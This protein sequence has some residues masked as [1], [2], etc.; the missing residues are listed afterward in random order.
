M[1]PAA[2]SDLILDPAA[3]PTLPFERQTDGSGASYTA[4]GYIPA[5]VELA[6]PT[7]GPAF[8]GVETEDV[9]SFTEAGTL[10]VPRGYDVRAGDRCTYQGRK[11]LVMGSRNWDLDHPLTG[12]DF[13]WMTLAL[14]VDPR[15]LIGDL[16]MLRGQQIALRPLV[17]TE[18]P[19]GGKDYGPG[20]ARPTQTFVLFN[21]KGFDGRENSQ[22]DRGMSRK[23]Q[24]QLVGAADAQIAIGD[25]WEDAVAKYT[26]EEVDRTRP[27]NVVAL[28]TGFLK[29]EGH[30]FG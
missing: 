10:F 30:G 15:E 2:V 9:T 1:V 7:S 25:S 14:Q 22:T 17:P 29:V 6:P 12:D 19:S 11:Y 8:M 28:V 21:T 24:F 3:A 13:G 18:K 20:P 26:V 16:L 27:Y 23:F 5:L 4:L